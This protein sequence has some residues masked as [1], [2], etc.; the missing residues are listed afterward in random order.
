MTITETETQHVRQDVP[1][2]V[3][4]ALKLVAIGIGSFTL[5]SAG[6]GIATD[7]I[8]LTV[9]LV[10]VWTFV[11]L[12]HDMRRRFRRP[13]FPPAGVALGLITAG[14]LMWLSTKASALFAGE[15]LAV[16]LAIGIAVVFVATFF[17]KE[18]NSIALAAIGVLGAVVHLCQLS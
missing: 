4:W 1:N 13:E 3:G 6:P 11:F 5:W 14:L 9:F 2:D 12:S 16:A 10:A 17:V 8:R 7:H 15:T 18:A